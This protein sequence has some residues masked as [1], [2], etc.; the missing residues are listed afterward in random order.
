MI[1]RLRGSYS[2]GLDTAPAV[3]PTTKLRTGS[4]GPAAALS[5]QNAASPLGGPGWG[6]SIEGSRRGWGARLHVAAGDA[7]GAWGQPQYT[8]M[9]H[10]LK[11]VQQLAHEFRWMFSDGQG[12]WLT[13]RP[14]GEGRP[15]LNLGLELR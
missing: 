3:V 7:N 2:G 12:A 10:G 4:D 11:R 8:I 5:W 13:V 14:T 1:G 9:A 6:A 15:R